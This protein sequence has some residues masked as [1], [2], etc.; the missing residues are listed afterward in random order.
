MDLKLDIAFIDHAN[1]VSS[2]SVDTNKKAYISL[3]IKTLIVFISKKIT[4]LNV[5][6]MLQ[7]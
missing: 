6:T 1:N 2:V 3:C 5:A 4:V 7:P